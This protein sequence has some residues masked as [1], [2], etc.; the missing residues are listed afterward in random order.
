MKFLPLPLKSSEVL[1]PVNLG[2]FVPS[3][4]AS[5][6]PLPQ[7]SLGCE[8]QRL[9]VSGPRGCK[10]FERTCRKRWGEEREEEE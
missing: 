6:A 9:E 7:H 10:V 5:A 3:V 2:R 1:S 8:S 4:C